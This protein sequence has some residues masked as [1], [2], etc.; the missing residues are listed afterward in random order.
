MIYS[1]LKDQLA[2]QQIA[3]SYTDFWYNEQIAILNK[4]FGGAKPVD[5]I[6]TGV[7]DEK[8]ATIGRAIQDPVFESSS[9]YNEAV[10]FYT[11]FDDFRTLLNDLKVSNYAELSSKGGVPTLMRNELVALGEKLMTNNPE[12]SF[13]YFGVFAGI[14][15]EA[16]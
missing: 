8:I 9:V 5:T 7:Q 11:K 14:L 10:E 12:F 2:E 1:M 16:K 4:Q 13:M 6:V 3:G 15:K